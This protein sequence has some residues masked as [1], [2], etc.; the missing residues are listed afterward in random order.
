MLKL[1]LNVAPRFDEATQY[2]YIWNKRLVD[3]LKRVDLLEGNAIRAKFN[4]AI[5]EHNPGTV[6]FYDHGSQTTLIGNDG[7]PLL[8]SSNVKKVS[9][10]E[11][12][13]MC[14]SAAKNLG[15]EAY[16]N[17]CL[18]WWGY[19]KPFAFT[20]DDEEIFGELANL[21]FL[22]RKVS[23]CTWPEARDRVID[24][25]NSTVDE[26]REKGGNPWT[27]IALVNNKNALVVYTDETPPESD[28]AWRNL[29]IRV[30]GKA[31]QHITRR[32]AM[33]TLI[34]TVC[35][36][37]ALHDFS[38]QVWQLKGTSISLEG[39]Y[40]GF[41]GMLLFGIDLINEYLKWLGDR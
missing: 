39:G 32:A 15:A 33:S 35:Y 11:V 4:E 12:Y 37:V 36:G 34:M 16:R 18:A 6:I 38:H 3:G 24:H 7:K 26:L 5:D 14:C 28:C 21:G 2:S 40:I 19:T 23:G 17:G 22:A 31:G 10:R 27:I 13:T 29:G 41:A 30:F 9:R 1:D 20:T 25:Y 8:D